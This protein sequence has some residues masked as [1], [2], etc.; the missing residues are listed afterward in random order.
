M[1]D[2]V[3][4]SW[5]AASIVMFRRCA[6][7]TEEDWLAS[8]LD[9]YQVIRA[10]AGEVE[11]LEKMVGSGDYETGYR[12]GE[13]SRSAD[14]QGAVTEWTDWPEGVEVTPQAVADRLAMLERLLV[15]PPADPAPGALGRSGRPKL[16][17]PPPKVMI[18]RAGRFT[19]AA[20]ATYNWT[21]HT[22]H[23]WSRERAIRRAKRWI[24]SCERSDRR[25]AEAEQVWP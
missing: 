18:R 17:M 22:F 3:T 15:S 4:T 2:D 20:D 16:P 6:S 12:E 21:G 8:G 24:E 14:F 10:L 13:N 9:V 7:M 25:C 1:S 5:P 23:A 19:W 11:R